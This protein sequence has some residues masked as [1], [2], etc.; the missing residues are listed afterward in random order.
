LSS[1][2]FGE[3]A[4]AL[5]QALPLRE[6]SGDRFGE[7]MTRLE[8]GRAY[9]GLGEVEKGATQIRSALDIAR[10][11]EASFVQAAALQALARLDRDR[12]NLL[13]AAAEI[14]E[15]IRILESVRADLPADR[16]RSSF[17]AAKRTYYDLYVDILMHLEDRV[18][19][20]GHAAKALL[21][22]EAARARS[23]LDLLAEGRLELTKGIDPQ[24]RQREKEIGSQLSQIQSQLIDE[25][26][27]ENP[28]AL[29]I[30][31]LRDQLSQVEE[32]RLDLEQRIRSA[33]RRYASVRY[34]Q[35]LDLS[36]IREH[37]DEQSALLEY[38]VGEDASYLF[39]VTRENH[40]VARLPALA[41]IEPLTLRLR[42]SL[43]KA[44]RNTRNDFPFVAHQLY[45]LLVAPA[46][47]ALAG[48][49]RLLI[50]PDGPLYVVPFEALLTAEA[51]TRDP[52]A[53]P[54]LLR[55]FAL[56]YIPSASVLPWLAEP[57]PSA[58]IAVPRK[59]FLAFADP[60]YPRE[61]SASAVLPSAPP[62]VRGSET[63]IGELQRLPETELEVEDIAGGYAR[64]EYVIYRRGEAT[65]AN[66]KENP[67]VAAAQTIHFA[68]HGVLDEER[69]ELSGLVLT[70]SGE[71]D[72]DG[73]LQTYEIFNLELSAELV[74]LSACE[75]GMGKQ[76][77]GEGLIGMSRAFL[78]AGAPR[79][80]VSL[81]RVRDDSAR[82]VMVRFYE[83]LERTGDKAQAL[84]EAKL[85]LIGGEFPHPAHWAPFILFGLP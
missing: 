59:R 75:T 44:D 72:D 53:M 46:R 77:T 3:A 63:V 29:R 4:K 57:P 50:A 39:V 70:R 17:F 10:A 19:G 76:V 82:Q 85:S 40:I 41:A 56:G 73:L 7:A 65:E 66:V 33:H 71:R 30:E 26:S 32:S 78:Y 68:T 79:V 18:P 74:V 69:P 9:Q 54:Y 49:S 34:P 80:V 60:I 47:A 16:L 5:E 36:Q 31:T 13:Q 64:D 45:E 42:A 22:S 51:A 8:L 52:A 58:E 2:E 1:K 81:W 11:T 83:A 61:I 35:P 12:A 14:Q 38:A 84:R 37:L 48:K 27:A 15:A 25:L 28:K 20:Q 21:V 62:A 24:L 55:E 23:L 67:L 6:R 43:V